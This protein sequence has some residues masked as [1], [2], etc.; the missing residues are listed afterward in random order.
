MDEIREL[1]AQALRAVEEAA[2]LCAD[3]DGYDEA[4]EI[5][6]FLAEDIAWVYDDLGRFTANESFEDD[7]EDSMDDPVDNWD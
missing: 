5:C 1:I 4:F 2:A 3:V 6:D 7:D